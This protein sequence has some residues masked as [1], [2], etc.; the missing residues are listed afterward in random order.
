MERGRHFIAAVAVGLTTGLGLLLDR[1]LAVAD[2][3]MLYVLAIGVVAYALGRGAAV[4]ASALSVLA[5]DYCFIEPRFTFAVNEERYW[6]TFAMMF[7][8]G[9]TLSGLTQRLRRESAAASSATLSAQTES[10]RS[11]LLS[12]VSHDLRTP[13]AII[14]GAASTLNESSDALSRD[15][16]E[17]LLTSI[18]E[19]SDRLER[20]VGNL[21]EMTR[22]ESKSLKP[23]REW[24]PVE[25]LLSSA[26]SR[27]EDALEGRAVSVQTPASLPLIHADPVLLEQVL[28]NLVENAAKYSPKGTSIELA[29]QVDGQELVLEVKD[30]GPGIPSGAEEKI[31][32]KFF[33]APQSS[34][35]PG[36]GLGLAICK[37]I[38]EV[39]GGTIRVAAREGGGS[40]FR[41]RLPIPAEQP[42]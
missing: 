13:L 33:R 25:E 36:A 1:H 10:M 39:H 32:E 22:L 20:L 40:S 15:E 11:A 38:V 24:L 21:L 29:A 41:L 2:L 7:V 16:K 4:T 3:V 26:L 27:L 37:G 5:F 42:A 23:R 6:L 8:V 9:L 35:T 18:T 12:A 28:I 31:F 30:R 34:G 19:E 14:K 17:G